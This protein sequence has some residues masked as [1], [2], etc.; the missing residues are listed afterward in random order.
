M[1]K[2]LDEFSDADFFVVIAEPEVSQLLE[3]AH[4]SIAEGNKTLIALGDAHVQQCNH[5]FEY[6][7]T[8]NT[9]EIDQIDQKMIRLHHNKLRFITSPTLCGKWR[10]YHQIETPTL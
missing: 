4:L 1:L 7:S 5:R 6:F 9:E 2:N 8:E 10:F 3:L